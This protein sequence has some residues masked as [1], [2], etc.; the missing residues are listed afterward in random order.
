VT[1]GRREERLAEAAREV[2]LIND[3]G[4]LIT[5]AP[6][7]WTA[8]VTLEWLAPEPGARRITG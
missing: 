2:L 6:Q 1:T 4:T 8:S 7:S 5:A 3:T